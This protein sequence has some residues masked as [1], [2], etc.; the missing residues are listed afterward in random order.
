MNCTLLQ[1]QA[2]SRFV[3]S[4]S[5]DLGC[6]S[7]PHAKDAKGQNALH[8]A[9]AEGRDSVLK[10]LIDEKELDVN[11]ANAAGYTPLHIAVK[12]GMDSSVQ[13][14]IRAKPTYGQKFSVMVKPHS[15]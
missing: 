6:V 11:T 9:A 15:S 4:F 2:I 7:D 10:Y 1:R 14:L 3:S 12:K 8:Y 13:L 5:A